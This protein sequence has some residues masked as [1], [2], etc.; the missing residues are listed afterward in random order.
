MKSSLLF[1]LVDI[2]IGNGCGQ[3]T[4]IANRPYPLK[5]LQ[6]DARLTAAQIRRYFREPYPA[7]S[8]K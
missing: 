4:F 1:A 3:H 6:A 7:K 8:A 5:S 2:V